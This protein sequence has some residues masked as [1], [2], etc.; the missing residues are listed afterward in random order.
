MGGDRS[1]TSR[2]PQKMFW[3]TSRKAALEQE[4]EVP[5]VSRVP[6]AEEVGRVV[7]RVRGQDECHVVSLDHKFNW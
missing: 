4:A 3:R 5:G 7:P 2:S 1:D 6:R